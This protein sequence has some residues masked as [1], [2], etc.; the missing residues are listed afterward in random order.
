VGF[1]LGLWFLVWMVAHRC[2]FRAGSSHIGNQAAHGLHGL[3][4]ANSTRAGV[5]PSPCAVGADVFARFC[6]NPAWKAF[7]ND[8]PIHKPKP[9]LYRASLLSETAL[10]NSGCGIKRLGEPI[11]A[12]AR[13]QPAIPWGPSPR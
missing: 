6:R 7:K 12:A 8:S 9:K 10:N 13:R 11:R 4:G 1:M 5:Y 2:G 3:R